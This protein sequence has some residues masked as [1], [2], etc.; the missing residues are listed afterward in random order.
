[1]GV[2]PLLGTILCGVIGEQFT[3]CGGECHVPGSG[4]VERA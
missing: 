2:G 4:E 3:L 1:M